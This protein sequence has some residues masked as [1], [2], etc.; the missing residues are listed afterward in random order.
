MVHRRH[1]CH[2]GCRHHKSRRHGSRNIL[3]KSV[4]FVKSTSKKIMPKVKSG[5]ESV[6]S[7]VVKSGE[8]TIPYLQRLTRKAFGLVSKG[9]KRRRRH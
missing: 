7:K 8:Q 3:N 1:T 2:K 9:T 5:L 4:H 6:G